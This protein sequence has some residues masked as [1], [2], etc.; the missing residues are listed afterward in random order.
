MRKFADLA[1]AF[2]RLRFTPSHSRGKKKKENFKNVRL[3]RTIV[4]TWKNIHAWEA[5]FFHRPTHAEVADAANR[6]R[7]RRPVRSFC[8]VSPHAAR[9]S[10]L[11]LSADRK[12][13]PQSAPLHPSLRSLDCPLLDSMYS[14]ALLHPPAPSFCSDPLFSLQCDICRDR[15]RWQKLSTNLPSTSLRQKQNRRK[16][17][18]FMRKSNSLPFSLV[19]ISKQLPSNPAFKLCC[20]ITCFTAS[21]L[22]SPVRTRNFSGLETF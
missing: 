2:P 15:Q 21:Q 12:P 3:G 11:K 17:R 4:L 16:N 20:Q 1:I 13:S 18:L 7:T 22:N 19:Y 6:Y 9:I 8:N 5:A 10:D 14:S